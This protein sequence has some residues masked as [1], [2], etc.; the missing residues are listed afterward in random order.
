MDYVK[1]EL[2]LE[3]ANA[4]NGGERLARFVEAKLAHWSQD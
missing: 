3:A 1:S 2:G 4:V